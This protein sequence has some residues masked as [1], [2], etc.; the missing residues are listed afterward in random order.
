[1]V[2]AGQTFR[3]R[4]SW[5]AYDGEGAREEIA[6]KGGRDAIDQEDLR[7]IYKRHTCRGERNFP[8]VDGKAV[9][10]W[11]SPTGNKCEA[12]VDIQSV[13]PASKTESLVKLA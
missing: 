1:M 6:S 7:E 3:A 5:T 9:P 2:D 8:Q 13:V 4:L 10:E 11:T 12:R